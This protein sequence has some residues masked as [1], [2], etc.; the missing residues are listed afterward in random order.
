MLARRAET[1]PRTTRCPWIWW[2]AGCAMGGVSMRHS[3][4][5]STAARC[6]S[7]TRRDR[8]DAAR[9]A[10]DRRVR[11]A[12]RGACRAGAGMTRHSS[13]CSRATAS[14]RKSRRKRC[15]CSTPRPSCMASISRPPRSL[16][17]RQGSPRRAMRFPPATRVGRHPG[18]RGPPWRRGSS[19][20]GRGGRQAASRGRSAGAP[21]AAGR[22][23]QPPP[24]HRA[25]G[26]GPRLAASSR[27]PRRGRPADR[28][29]AA[30]RALLRPA[31]RARR[32]IGPSTPCATRSPRSSASPGWRSRRRAAAAGR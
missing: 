4:S 3:S 6:C 27:A 18:R 29:R 22:L 8:P 25:P 17:A 13:P 2:A 32:A 5:T 31:A 21:P 30:R 26:A 7:G 28:A 11:A 24:G 16:W 23:R 20:A 10:Q 9:G 14:V 15:A 1:A 12:S 19:L